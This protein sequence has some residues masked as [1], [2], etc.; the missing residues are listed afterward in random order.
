M[1]GEKQAFPS[2]ADEYFYFA[3]Y[4]M[5]KTPNDFVKELIFTKDDFHVLII[6]S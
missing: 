5:K 1:E 6:T 4:A 3:E 2:A